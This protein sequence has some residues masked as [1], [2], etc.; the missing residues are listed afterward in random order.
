MKEK[1]IEHYAV[2]DK[3]KQVIELLPS[4]INITIS[5][6]ESWHFSLCFKCIDEALDFLSGVEGVRPIAMA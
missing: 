3:C 1:K 4:N 5:P 2:C 6:N